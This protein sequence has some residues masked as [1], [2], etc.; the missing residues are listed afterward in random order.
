MAGRLF[1][2]DGLR[3][4]AGEFPLDA[5]TVHALGMAL[6]SAALRLAAQPEVV[7]GMDTRESGPWI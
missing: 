7:L 1:G 4:L 5:K 2:T 3:G 6:G